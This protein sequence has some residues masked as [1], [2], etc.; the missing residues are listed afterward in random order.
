VSRI[1][2]SGVASGGT[3]LSLYLIK[4]STADIGTSNST[5]SM[6]VVPLDSKRGYPASTA[7][8]WVGAPGPVGT[9]IGQLDAQVVPIQPASSGGSTLP[10]FVFDYGPT[11]GLAPIRLYKGEQLALNFG[12]LP[13]PS[14]ASVFC[15]FMWNEGGP[16]S[17]P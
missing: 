5:V 17:S 11:T 12:G 2:V 3:T 9:L 13:M 15:S 7:N 16:Q 4:R 10:G 1:K 8:Y 6:T 14:G